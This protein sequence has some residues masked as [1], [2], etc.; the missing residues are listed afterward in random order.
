MAEDIGD[1]FEVHAI[2]DHPGRQAMPEH[3]RSTL[4]RHNPSPLQTPGDDA[5]YG[6]VVPEWTERP[7]QPY[8]YVR[9]RSSPT[10]SKQVPRQGSPDTRGH[11]QHPFTAI[12][13]VSDSNASSSPVDIGKLK[14][15]GLAAAQSE[16]SDQQ[17]QSL[18]AHSGGARVIDTLDERLDLLPR[19]VARDRGELPGKD[20]RYRE[21]KIH[22]GHTGPMKVSQKGPGTSD[23]GTLPTRTLMSAEQS[24]REIKNVTCAESCQPLNC[25]ARGELLQPE[26]GATQVCEAGLD[27]ETANV[28]QVH[29][30][31]L[32]K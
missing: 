5:R 22:L 19:D 26:L 12:F 15:T 30:I 24:R 16:R 29:I 32:Q 11:W 25:T 13:G 1:G 17:D 7:V 31:A 2:V 18:V 8:E 14:P 4:W 3:V 20:V 23:H 28:P 6:T 9:D 10:S 21:T 27:T